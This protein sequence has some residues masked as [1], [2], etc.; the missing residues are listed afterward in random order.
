MKKLPKGKLEGEK[1]ISRCD[2]CGSRPVL[3]QSY[4]ENWHSHLLKIEWLCPDCLSI[5]RKKGVVHER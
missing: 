5:M 1:D 4:V 2:R 3:L